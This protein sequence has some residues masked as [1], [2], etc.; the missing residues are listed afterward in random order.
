MR[1]LLGIAIALAVGAGCRLPPGDGAKPVTTTD[2]GKRPWLRAGK[3]PVVVQRE[4]NDCG[5]AALAMVAGAWGRQWT[6]D[7]LEKTLHPVGQG[8]RLGAMRDF[9]RSRGLEAFAIKGTRADL[10]HELRL[11]RPVLLGLVL[12]VDKEH[13][14]THYEV[15]VAID[16]RT[17]D[18]VTI[19]PA[20][21]EMQQ[22]PANIFD[23]EWKTAGYAT[24]VVVGDQSGQTAH[25]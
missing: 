5:P 20:S 3:T 11:G 17:G 8:V 24:L 25:R 4:E 9:A 1:A 16:P 18:I 13:N 23:L 14:R 2:L 7:D 19:D 15:A 22:R 10:E 12:P 6:L 21:G